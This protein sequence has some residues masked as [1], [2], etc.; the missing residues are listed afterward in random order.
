MD[1]KLTVH[2]PQCQDHPRRLRYL[3]TV[4]LGLHLGKHPN[5]GRTL[6]FN[7]SPTDDKDRNCQVGFDLNTGGLTQPTQ[8]NHALLSHSG[9]I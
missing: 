5:F 3:P 7:G 8:V 1:F 6:V 9:D 4:E 2:D